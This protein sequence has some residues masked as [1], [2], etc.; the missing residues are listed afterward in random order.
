VHE[1]NEVLKCISF[2][3]FAKTIIPFYF[4]TFI[5]MQYT[6]RIDQMPLHKSR[7]LAAVRMPRATGVGGWWQVPTFRLDFFPTSIVW[8]S[9]STFL[10]TSAVCMT[11]A[12]SGY[13]LLLLLEW[14]YLLT[15]CNLWLHAVL[16]HYKP[17]FSVSLRF[18]SLSTTCEDAS[19]LSLQRWLFHML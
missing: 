18:C 5:A 12:S 1:T 8:V 19:R 11:Q 4:S 10:K 2:P 13:S 14:L 16:Q 6:E 9:D 15:M 3:V 17:K 7:T